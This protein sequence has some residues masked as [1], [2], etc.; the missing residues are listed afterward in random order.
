MGLASGLGAVAAF[1]VLARLERMS[2]KFVLALSLALLF[3]IGFGLAA[4]PS[5]CGA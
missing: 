3:P 5:A 2:W 4:I 1:G